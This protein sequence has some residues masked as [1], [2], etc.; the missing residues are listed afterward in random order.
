[1]AMISGVIRLKDVVSFQVQS[2]GFKEPR[3][4]RFFYLRTVG[5]TSLNSNVENQ[6]ASKYLILPS[7]HFLAEKK[8]TVLKTLVL[9]FSSH[10]KI[11]E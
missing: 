5:A 6:V 4:A 2:G 10:S 8:S 9:G 11:C 1:M 7:L 3:R